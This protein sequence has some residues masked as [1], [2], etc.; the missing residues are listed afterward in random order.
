V[1]ELPFLGQEGDNRLV[2]QFIA[3]GGAPAF[4][5][6]AAQVQGAWLGLLSRCRQQRQ[7]WLE[8]VLLRLGTLQALAGDWCRL[9]PWLE[10]E[11]VTA[12]RLL[13]EMLQPVLR[14]PV[15][16]SSSA[17]VLRRSLEELR[18]SM[19]RF[20]QCWV[21]FLREVDLGPVNKLRENYNRYYVLEKE[22]II[23][24]PILARR[25][26]QPMKPATLTDLE[27]TLPYLPT[28]QMRP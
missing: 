11:Q 27:E 3:Q 4:M 13:A 22:C 9:Q 17:G 7:E 18:E 26:F 2:Q 15:A 20:N 6:R 1:D 12:L 25:G 21:K 14:V 19:E 10:E 16:E 23:G 24:S 8:M 5:N 28:L